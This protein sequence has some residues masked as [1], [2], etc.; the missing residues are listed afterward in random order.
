MYKD[1]VFAFK[2]SR[3][4]DQSK[5][6][7]LTVCTHGVRLEQE[8]VKCDKKAKALG[9]DKE[10]VAYLKETREWIR[11]RGGKNWRDYNEC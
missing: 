6:H 3:P 11:D 9:L 10:S 5:L 2:P 4:I 8:C 7:L 1:N